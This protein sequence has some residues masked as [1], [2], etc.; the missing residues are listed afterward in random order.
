VD[1]TVGQLGEGVGA[2][3]DHLLADGVGPEGPALRVEEIP[4]VDLLGSDR[5]VAG[6][7]SQGQT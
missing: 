6:D 5:A 7:A 2:V 3:D 1:L 4:G